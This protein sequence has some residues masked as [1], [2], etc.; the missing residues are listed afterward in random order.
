MKIDEA[1]WKAQYKA[2]AEKFGELGSGPSDGIVC[3]HASIK[4]IVDGLAE[5]AKAATEE[6][7]FNVE[8][9][10]TELF[11]SCKDGKY[12]GFASNASAAMKAA[13]LSVGK[14]LLTGIKSL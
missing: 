9:S 10:L 6:K 11:L 5:D 7:P 2:S 14:T 12:N 4:Y 1:K 8:A 13:G 3:V